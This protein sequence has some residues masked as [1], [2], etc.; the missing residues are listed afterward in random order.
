MSDPEVLG[1]EGPADAASRDSPAA[2]GSGGSAD[3]VERLLSAVQRALGAHVAR[4]E[5][6]PVAQSPLAPLG[7]RFRMEAVGPGGPLV[8]ESGPL[9]AVLV[10]FK[11]A[12]ETF[13]LAPASAELVIEQIAARVR[14]IVHEEV[15]VLEE[16][17]TER[18]KRTTVFTVKG[19]RIA[20]VLD[21]GLEPTATPVDGAQLSSFGGTWSRAPTA[22]ERA[23]MHRLRG[24]VMGRLKRKVAATLFDRATGAVLGAVER[25]AQGGAAGA[26]PAPD[27]GRRRLKG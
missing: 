2:M 18:L 20:A 8:V 11:A 27:D 19:G 9:G 10:G 1:P 12:R 24:G 26:G 21:E 4:S 16:R 14:A 7:V 15:I 13:L 23:L 5:V 6:V 22:D 17:A 25:A 3:V